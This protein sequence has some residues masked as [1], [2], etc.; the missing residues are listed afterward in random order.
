MAKKP[1]G[2]KSGLAKFN[3]LRRRAIRDH[4]KFNIAAYRR[5]KSESGKT[6][7]YKEYKKYQPKRISRRRKA[8]PMANFIARLDYKKTGKDFNADL[9]VKAPAD[10]TFSQ[11]KEIVKDWAGGIGSDVKLEGWRGG[12][13]GSRHDTINI[14]RAIWAMKDFEV[15]GQPTDGDSENFDDEDDEEEEE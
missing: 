9:I 15:T 2:K 3:A 5:A 10:A 11:L 7:A 8:A 4:G 14:K 6:P 1:K 12:S 13:Q